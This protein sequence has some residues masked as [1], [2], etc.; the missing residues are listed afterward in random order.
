[1]SKTMY[2]VTDDRGNGQV[3]FD[4]ERAERLSQAG[5]DVT[6]TVI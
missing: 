2:H 3:L 4:A 6:A 5:L 1:M